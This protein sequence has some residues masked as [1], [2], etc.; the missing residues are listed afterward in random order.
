MKKH[1]AQ[2]KIL[3]LAVVIGLG[4]SY[5]SAFGPTAPAPGNNV[6]GFL[7]QS[8]SEQSKGGSLLTSILLDVDN[9][10]AIINDALSTNSIAVLN[11]ATVVNGDTYV[12]SLTGPSNVCA[13]PLGKLVTCPSVPPPPSGNSIYVHIREVPDDQR[14]SQGC[15][16]YGTG[17]G[18]YNSSILLGYIGSSVFLDFYAS[19]ADYNAGT[20]LNVTGTNLVISYNSDGTPL[21]IPATGTSMYLTNGPGFMYTEGQYF[22]QDCEYWP[23]SPTQTGSYSVTNGANA[24]VPYTLI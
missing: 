8:V 5:A 11:N 4:A 13:D 19:A 6:G 23:G 17:S 10:S 3:I 21:T 7:D 22:P 12:N 20:P 1:L 24:T 15:Y 9:P 16:L 14:Y 2:F 18:P